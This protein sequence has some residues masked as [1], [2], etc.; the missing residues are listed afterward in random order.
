MSRSIIRVLIFGV[1]CLPVVAESKG[2]SLSGDSIEYDRNKSIVRAKGDASLVF[3][4]RRVDS[5]DVEFNVDTGDVNFRKMFHVKHE[6]YSVSANQF[7]FKNK[8]NKGEAEQFSAQVGK[9]YFTGEKVSISPDGIDLQDAVF[10]TCSSKDKHFYLKSERMYI[11]P[12]WGVM[13]GVNNWLHMPFL[14]FDVWVPSYVYGSSQYSV[15]AGPLPE[16]GTNRI[17]GGY[18]KQEFNYFLTPHSTGVWGIGT[19]E[20]RGGYFGVVHQQLID[21]KQM[22]QADIHYTDRDKI[23]GGLSYH[24][25][26][27]QDMLEEEK[28]DLLKIFDTKQSG[29]IRLIVE[30]KDGDFIQDSIVDKLPFIQIKGEGI[31]SKELRLKTNWKV[32]WG[33]IREQA[34]S[35]AELTQ[36]MTEAEFRLEKAIDIKNLSSSIELLYKGF[37]YEEDRDWQRLFI[38]WE[39]GIPSFVFK[40]KVIFRKELV[41]QGNPFFDFQQLNAVTQDEVGIELSEKFLDVEWTFEGDYV[42]ETLDPRQLKFQVGKTFHC[43][44][45]DLA[46]DTVFERF[47]FGV[48]LF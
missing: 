17:E 39:S 23:E 27:Y 28:D 43:W 41:N 24:W 20:K 22:V 44:G 19:S 18:I 12:V 30:I 16:F 47:S 4:E 48:R 7:D 2:V 35:G 11:Y 33:A 29:E 1:M 32:G 46:W 14:P 8:S 40:P 36:N 5:Q 26:L 34:L 6:N 38:N 15:L 25:I 31:E 45:I 9:L 42:L 10:S 13:V 37:W 3:D 21:D